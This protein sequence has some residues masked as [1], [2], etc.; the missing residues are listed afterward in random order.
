MKVN[1]V[2]SFS[3]SAGGAV[4]VTAD[5]GISSH[6]VPSSVLSSQHHLGP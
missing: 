5:V 3:L 6:H 2:E 4:K 1:H